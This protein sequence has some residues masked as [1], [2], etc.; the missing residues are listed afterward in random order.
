M[1]RQ[2]AGALFDMIDES[3]SH[4]GG[5]DPKVVPLASVRKS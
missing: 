5:E 4:A 2:H 3:P 1:R